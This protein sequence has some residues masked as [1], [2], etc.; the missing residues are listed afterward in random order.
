MAQI[1]ALLLVSPDPLSQ[2]DIMEQLREHGIDDI[3]D[4]KQCALESDGHF[5]VI[6][7][8]D[9]DGDNVPRRAPAT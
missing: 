9:D 4:V 7:F 2:D 8:D 3:T 1:H 6:K 5:S